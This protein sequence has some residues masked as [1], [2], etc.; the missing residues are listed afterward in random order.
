MK[1]DYTTVN[2]KYRLETFNKISSQKRLVK[3]LTNKLINNSV[4]IY[5]QKTLNQYKSLAK[6]KSS[7]KKTKDSDIKKVLKET[8]KQTQ[9]KIN[10]SFK[11]LTGY[12][13]A[14]KRL[15]K[16]RFEDKLQLRGGIDKKGKSLS[17]KMFAAVPKSPETNVDGISS[18]KAYLKEAETIESVLRNKL[19]IRKG[20]YV[21]GFRYYDWVYRECLAAGVPLNIDLNT[22]DEYRINSGYITSTFTEKGKIVK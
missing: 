15:G 9:E 22:L 18:Y 19:D 1:K 17:I 8:I 7:L 3:E 11:Q 13:I 6:L 20:E 2:R 21:S 16:S 4:R 5:A 10:Y 12:N 14:T